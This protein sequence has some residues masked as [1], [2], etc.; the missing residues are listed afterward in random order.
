VVRPVVCLQTG[1]GLIKNQYWL[2][3]GITLVGVLIGSLGPMAL[4]LGP[5][6]CGIYLCLFA[7]FRGQPVTFE[8]L[9]KGFDYFV[10][11]LIATLIQVI[12]ISLLLLPIYA[13]FFIRFMGLMSA[14]RV[15]TRGAP[16]DPSEM[17]SMFLAMGGMVLVVIFI[18]TLVGAFFIFTYPLIV[19]RKLKALDAVRTSFKAVMANLG[20]VLGLMGLNMVLGVIGLIFCY[21]GAILLMPVSFAGWAVAYRQVFPEQS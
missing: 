11:G 12:P 18:S 4:L 14:P 7:H 15:R 10:Q 1:W 19:D 13:I 6:M 2:F 21:V 8:L 3:L 9:F 5:M 17:Y 16:V 20:G